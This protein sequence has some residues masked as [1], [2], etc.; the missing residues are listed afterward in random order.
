ACG[1]S[2]G[3]RAPIAA[4]LNPRVSFARFPTQ[5]AELESALESVQAGLEALQQQAGAIL[6]EPIQGRGG[7][8]VPP[9][10]FL[11]RLAEIA[12]AH[13]TLLIVDEI[14]TGLA[15]TGPLLRA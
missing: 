11:P 13:G 9:P 6:V 15:R 3:F 5:E 10:A 12:R 8:R 1:Y 4:Q 7:V 14:Y 2:A